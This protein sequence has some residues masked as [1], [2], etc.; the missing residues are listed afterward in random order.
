MGTVTYENGIAILQLIVFPIIFAAAVFIWKRS[1]WRAGGKIWRYGATLSLI[2]IAG[3]I[4]S[5]LTIDH[6]SRDVRVAV[7]VCELIGMAP[8]ILTFL[9]I[10]KQIDIEQRIPTRISGVMVILCF[11]GLILGIASV[12]GSSGNTY[13]PGGLTKAAMGL[14]LAVFAIYNLMGMWLWLQLQGGMRRFQKK[15]FLALALSSPFLLVRLV[16]SA[17]SDYGHDKRFVLFGDETIYLCMNVLEEII[18]M[19]IA[20]ALG[21]SAVMESDFQRLGP[22]EPAE[23]KGD[24]V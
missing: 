3:S 15:L 8:L 5:L 2:R 14:F 11:I 4:S 19:A 22:K 18:A 7:A 23:P 6:D 13:H 10:L 20:M 1:G 21:M 12:S 17:I 16:Y 24:G 9:G